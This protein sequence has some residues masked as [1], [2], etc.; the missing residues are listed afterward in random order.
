M[1]TSIIQS[2]FPANR[3][4]YKTIQV[5]SQMDSIIMQIGAGVIFNFQC[6]SIFSSVLTKNSSNFG[7]EIVDVLRYT[8]NTPSKISHKQIAQCS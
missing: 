4:T 5:N 7:L 1:S 2:N 6:G 3:K 8:L